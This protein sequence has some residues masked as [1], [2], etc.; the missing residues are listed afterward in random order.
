MRRWAQRR[1]QLCRS[2]I[3]HR[4][5][6]SSNRHRPRG[7]TR[8]HDR[9][10]RPHQHDG[11]PSR[12]RR[13]RHDHAQ[14]VPQV[15]QAR[16]STAD[17]QSVRPAHMPAAGCCL[18]G[19]PK[20]APARAPPPPC[21]PRQPTPQAAAQPCVLI[22]T[23]EGIESKGAHLLASEV[24]RP[25]PC[26]VWVPQLAR[27]GGGRQRAHDST[28]PPGAGA[29]APGLRGRGPG[30]RRAQRRPQRGPPQLRLPAPAA[31]PPGPGRRRLEPGR[32]HAGR[33]HPVRGRPEGGA[34]APPAAVARPR[35][36]GHRPR[37]ST[38]QRG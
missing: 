16:V 33:L 30:A 11:P 21:R 15:V 7:P 20:H 8:P 31:A 2:L 24:R 25:A 37:P 19:L 38:E 6:K 32:R 4:S 35:R 13:R 22:T 1:N 29:A 14:D 27:A 36:G 10:P 5:L 17:C 9:P 18:Q 23:D 3:A 28:A 26:R 34:A 12:S